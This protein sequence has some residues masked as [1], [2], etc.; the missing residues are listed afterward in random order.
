LGEP[1]QRAVEEDVFAPGEL[2]IEAGAELEERGDAA[3]H[4]DAAGGRPKG[5]G[6][7]LEQRAL[8]A[9]VAADDAERGAAREL[10]GDVADRPELAVVLMPPADQDLLQAVLR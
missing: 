10:E 8:A 6:D 1:E 4:L 5:A 7:E 3:A 2:G 9:A